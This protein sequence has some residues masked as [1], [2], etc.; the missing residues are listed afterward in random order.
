MAM[1][2]SLITL[3][4]SFKILYG[5]IT[6]NVKLCGLKRKPYL[7]IFGLVQTA[8]MFT[9]FFAEFDDALTVALFLMLASLSNAFS[10]VVVDAILIVQA[11]RDPEFGS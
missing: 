11:R 8:A 9:L 2:T 7:I 3:P 10:N 1:Y 6:D 4:W 5:L